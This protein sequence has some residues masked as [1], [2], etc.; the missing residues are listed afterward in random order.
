MET[1]MLFI[2]ENA[3]NAHYIIFGL[4]LLAGFNIPVSEDGMLFISALIASKYPENFYLLFFG[5]YLGAYFSDL[6]C[7]GLG[8]HFGPK[9]WKIKFFAKIVSPEKVDQLGGFY[10]KYGVFTLLLGRFIPFGVRNGLFLTAGLSKMNFLKFALSDL[11]ACTISCTLFFNLYYKFG[12]TVIEYVK[13]GN[14]IIF[15][16]FLIAICFYFIKRKRL[17]NQ[18]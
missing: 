5:V 1:F 7:Y 11:L 9:I 8:R 12:D 14:M 18:K 13:K 6:I 2:Q 10:K 3:A 4:L 15:G 16:V 17:I